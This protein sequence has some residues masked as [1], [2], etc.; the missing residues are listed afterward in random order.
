MATYGMLAE[1]A[2]AER[3]LEAAR[4]TRAAGYS[5]IEA[6]SPMPVEDLAAAVGPFRDRIPML[7]LIGGILGAVGGYFMQWYAATISYPINVGGR[8]L[9]SWPSFVPV[10][11]E[12][13]VLG[14]ALFAVFGMLALNR[15][16][17][18]HH[19]L[20]N[21]PEFELASRNRFF[22]CIRCD[23]PRYQQQEVRR[24]FETLDPLLVR[25]VPR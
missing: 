15:L 21:V 17:K 22:L 13:A 24:F 23:D 1:F 20:F 4:Q 18:L 3:L 7:T 8:P 6:Y 9:H 10:T 5:R 2:G 14:A 16:P 11:F 12:T 25:E 19:P